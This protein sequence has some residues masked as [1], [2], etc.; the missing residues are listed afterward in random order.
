MWLQVKGSNANLTSFGVLM[1]GSRDRQTNAVT[2]DR[3]LSVWSDDKDT[4]KAVFSPTGAE[5]TVGGATRTLLESFARA[6]GIPGLSCQS[7]TCSI[8]R[9]F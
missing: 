2:Y 9:S 7:A 3:P 6:G 1:Q 4:V 8:K 5:L